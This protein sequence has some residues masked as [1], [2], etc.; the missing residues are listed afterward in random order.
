MEFG[1]SSDQA[2]FAESLRG[3]LG[4][5]FPITKVRSV[6]ESAEGRD[7]ELASGLA[8]QGVAGLL[9][10]EEFGGSAM[11]LVEAVVA[12]EELGR[13][14]ATWSFHTASVMAPLALA[15][16]GSQQQKHDW[17]PALATARSHLSFAA[18]DLTLRDDRL[19]GSLPVVADA[20][21]TEAFIVAAACDGTTSLLLV[22]RQAAGLTVDVLATVDQT[23]RVGA[24]TFD[25]VEVDE[26]MRLVAGHGPELCQRIVDA[27]RIV[28]AADMLGAAQRVLEL[29]VEYAMTRR[30]FGRPVGS[31]Q[32]VKHMCAETVAEVEPLRS[33]LWYAALAWQER[34]EDASVVASLLKAHAAEVATRAVTTATQVFG[35][36]GFTWECDIHIWFKRVGY[37]RQMFG[38]PA[39][40]RQHAALLQ[41]GAPAS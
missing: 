3:Y 22:P 35:G 23:R 11:G 27:G 41:F 21:Y 12:A 30:Q 2:L 6:M 20:A 1:L 32:S 15:L 34:R 17:L 26:S 4:E 13:A 38:G 19:T 28:L 8:G 25:G 7:Q 40:C 16:A 10:A 36:M 18:G 37:D 5:H 9:I 39:V 29:S 14:A 33:L 31:F 24:V